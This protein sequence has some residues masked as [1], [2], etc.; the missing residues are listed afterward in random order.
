MATGFHEHNPKGFTWPSSNMVTFDDN[1]I[2]PVNSPLALNV[3]ISKD[4]SGAP[5][6]VVYTFT[7][8][9]NTL[10]PNV[11]QTAIVTLYYTGSPLAF[12]NYVVSFNPNFSVNQTPLQ[13]IYVQ[14]TTPTSPLTIGL[15]W[16]E[17]ISSLSGYYN[18]DDTYYMSDNVP[19]NAATTP[20]LGVTLVLTRRVGIITKSTT[21]NT[22]LLPHNNKVEI[23][24][25]E[26]RGQTTYNAD[27][28]SDMTFI[29]KD[30]YRYYDYDS[31]IIKTCGKCKSQYGK[32]SKLKTTK[33]LQFSPPLQNVVK[34]KGCNLKEKLYNYYLT[35]QCKFGSSF[36]DDFYGPLIL[37]S[38]F[39][40]ILAK[41]L[42]GD[43]N[44]NY[45]CQNFNKQ[46]FKDLKQSR[47]CGAI[48]FFCDEEYRGFYKVFV[49]CN[50][51]P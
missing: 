48:D 49:K 25:I 42:Y 30:K 7:F 21:A 39:K 23:P 44:I 35:H 37:Y 50:F 40:Y 10:G 22:N 28:L 24:I 32:L 33:F 27:Y 16:L 13:V 4:V 14:S 18:I 12:T 41:L 47:F 51:V 1:Y 2:P 3:I 36:N 45:L 6:V 29:I 9:S 11:T 5:A 8:Y 15:E 46:F 26:I 38:M 43:F 20:I 34:G 31:K 19:I 17:G